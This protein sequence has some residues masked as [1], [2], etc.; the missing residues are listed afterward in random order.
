MTVI[1]A[2]KIAVLVLMLVVSIKKLNGMILE[3]TKG[4]KESRQKRRSRQE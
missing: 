1:V 4:D 2:L 3:L